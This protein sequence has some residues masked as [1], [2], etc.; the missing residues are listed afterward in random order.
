MIRRAKI[1]RSSWK[2]A[3]CSA[4]RGAVTNEIY[5]RRACPANDRE[6]GR[7]AARDKAHLFCK[8]EVTALVF[9]SAKDPVLTHH[10]FSASHSFGKRYLDV[11]AEYASE[12][13]LGALCAPA[14]S[15]TDAAANSP[16]TLALITKTLRMLEFLTQVRPAFHN[17]AFN[18]AAFYDRL[19]QPFGSNR[20]HSYCH[21]HS[22]RCR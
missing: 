4:R 19:E 14:E 1:R 7:S 12:Q 18:L 21:Q 10:C 20:G 17:L 13:V 2:G 3:R 8:P 15:T 6:A 5:N 16:A 9:G 11:H 22:H